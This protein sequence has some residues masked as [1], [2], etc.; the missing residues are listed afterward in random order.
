[1]TTITIQRREVTSQSL[2]SLR[3]WADG[4]GSGE[5][6]SEAVCELLDYLDADHDVTISVHGPSDTRPLKITT[7]YSG[8][9]ETRG[10]RIT[11][12][13]GGSQVTVPYD[14]TAR[15]PHIVA[16][17]ALLRSISR[18]DADTIELDTLISRNTL[19]GFRFDIP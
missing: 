15:D 2:R 18:P 10:S 6:L 17:R 13:G 4:R 1:M 19:T 11:A 12:R 7:S 9:T 14:Y 5:E 16:A 8:P 3:Q